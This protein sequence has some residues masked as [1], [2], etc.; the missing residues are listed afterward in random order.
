MITWLTPSTWLNRCAMT[1][2]AASNTSEE[3]R[4]EEAIESTR[5]GASAGFTLRYV[6]GFGRSGGRSFAAALIAACTSRAAASTGRSRSNWITMEV[7]PSVLA[8]VISVTPEIWLKRR[9]SGA[10]SD[11]ATVAGSAPGSVAETVTIGKSTR[12][13]E[14]TG[15][16]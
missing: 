2:S 7:P 5:I 15:N 14:A 1:S 3:G 11:E 16:A 10:A 4:V 12:G 9:S 6:G 8:E 13:S